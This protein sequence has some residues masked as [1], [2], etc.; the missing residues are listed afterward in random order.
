MSGNAV[1]HV[2]DLV[3]LGGWR[4]QHEV[5]FAVDDDFRAGRSGQTTCGESSRSTDMALWPRSRQSRFLPGLL[6]TRVE[7]RGRLQKAEIRELPPIAGVMEHARAGAAFAIGV[8]GV[9]RECR[10]A[11]GDEPRHRESFGK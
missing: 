2:A 8:T 11:A 5:L 7:Q 3:L 6:I 9:N 4:F 10:R 1:E